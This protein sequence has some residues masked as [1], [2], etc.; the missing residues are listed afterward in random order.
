[1][2]NDYD[3]TPER[4]RGALISYIGPRL[5]VDHVIPDLAPVVRGITARNFGI[6]IPT[7]ARRVRSAMRGKIALD[8]DIDDLSELL[9][10]IEEI[11][12]AEE[13]GQDRRGAVRDAMRRRGARDEDLD[14]LL[15]RLGEGEDN[16][17][18]N[19]PWRDIED[20]RA[21]LGKDVPPPFPGRPLQG[22]MDPME[23]GRNDTRFPR[24]GAPADKGPVSEERGGPP[25]SEAI[26]RL[27]HRRAGD[28][29]RPRHFGAHDSA[30][31]SF[32][33]RFAYTR[34]TRTDSGSG[35]FRGKD[36][37]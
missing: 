17:P 30:N 22:R 19:E 34:G 28:I 14:E 6:M 35:I 7:I 26:D 12:E 21:R 11:R 16:E 10:C 36:V 5:A 8:A 27:P 1:M 3:P 15:E 9:D 13:Q 4:L 25:S 24:G 33:D 31:N 23:N 20:R 2:P 18:T 37:A 29:D 32:R